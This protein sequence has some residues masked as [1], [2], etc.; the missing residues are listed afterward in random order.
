MKITTKLSVVALIPMCM[1]FMAVF[2]VSLVSRQVEEARGRAR[3]AASIMKGVAELNQLTHTYLLHREERP[4]M[5]FLRKHG[6]LTELMDALHCRD[7]KQQEL[8]NEIREDHDNI[9]KLFSSLVLRYEGRGA[10][11]RDPAFAELQERLAGQ[12]LI[13]S[14]SILSHTILL[15]ASIEREMDSAQQKANRVIVLLTS[16]TALVITGIL[17]L[18]MGIIS[19][20]IRALRKG[21]EI[22]GSGDLD[23]KL[24]IPTQDE[25]GQLAHAFDRMTEQLKTV[26]VSRDLLQ[27][28][29]EERKRVERALRRSEDRLKEAQRIASLG[30]WEWDLSTK[31]LKWSDEVYRIM[32]VQ[33]QDFELSFESFQ[34]FVHPDD[35]HLVEQTISEALSRKE[36]CAV[37]YRVIRRDG[38]EIVVQAQA[39]VVCSVEGTPLRIIGTIQDITERK[40]LEEAIRYQANHD[41]LTGLPNRVLFMEHLSRGI[42][43]AGRNR[44]HLAVMF[45][46]LDRFKNINDSLGHSAGDYLLKQVAVRLSSHVRESDTVARLGGDEFILLLPDIAHTE[47]ADTVARKI[48]S[49]F[50]MPF[51]IEGNEVYVSPSMGVSLY[52]DD[53]EYAEELIKNADIAMYH[54]KEQGRG[55]YQFYSP[56]MNIRTLERM[57]LENSLRQ[58]LERGELV[59]Y[60]QPQVESVTRRVVSAEALV[61]WQHPDLGLLNPFQFLPIAE[62]TGLIMPLDEWVL[63]TACAQVREWQDE[64]FPA[65]GITVNLS[66]RQFQQPGLTEMLFR[67]M[68]ET[69]LDPSCLWLEITEGVAMKDIGLTLRNLEKLT[70]RGVRFCIDD[71]GTGYSSLSYLKRLPVQ[72]VKI[73]KSFV[74]HLAESCDDRAIITAVITLAHSLRMGVVAEGVETEEQLEILRSVGCDEIQGFL[75]GKPVPA[76][77][78]KELL[79]SSGS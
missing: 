13:R 32:G 9:G 16:V 19:R 20:S 2:S 76:E 55:N 12:I 38:T 79:L 74:T 64:G 43:Q 63:R 72:K 29:V 18:V 62:E 44:T 71:F 27:R 31:R 69:D 48:L 6:G 47:Y 41:L 33:L 58:T 65:I 46:D 34:S 3:I 68:K 45:L 22:I 35:R 57:I 7:R 21:I 78:F 39:E 5:Q 73:D 23:Y 53:S 59:V 52:P 28:E 15:V 51:R 66:A 50:R 17:L 26:T 56:A 8:V 61:R 10:M 25:I 49:L 67:V 60:Y 11:R 70:E 30:N 54:A 40:L 42:A 24:G 37:D 75:F 1:A 77:I 36:R 14:R 4:K